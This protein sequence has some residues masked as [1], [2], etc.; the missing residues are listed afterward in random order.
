[1]IQNNVY[2]RP[3][4]PADSQPWMENTVFDLQLVESTNVTLWDTEDRMYL[5]FLKSK[6]KWTHEV[7]THIVQGS[8]LLPK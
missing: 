2:T 1:M 3:S 5:Y 8:T 6:Y 4:A 7:Q